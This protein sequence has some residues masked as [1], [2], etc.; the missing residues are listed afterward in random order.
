MTST[1]RRLRHFPVGSALGAEFGCQ[2]YFLAACLEH[3]R[4]QLFV[5]AIAIDVGGVEKIDSYVDGAIQGRQIGC[6]VCRTVEIGHAHAA[7]TNGRDLES[8]FAERT[9]GNGGDHAYLFGSGSG[10]R[11]L[12]AMQTTTQAVRA[13]DPI[14][15]R[16]CLILPAHPNEGGPIPPRRA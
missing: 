15:A 10:G 3:L 12:Q 14:V 16:D 11:C 9:A 5:T 8:L 2:N 4:Q 1:L 7:E 6:V 13:A